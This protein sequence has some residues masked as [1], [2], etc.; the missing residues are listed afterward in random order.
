MPA[1]GLVCGGHCRKAL[2]SVFLYPILSLVWKD[3]SIADIEEILDRRQP[4]DVWFLI[5]SG[6]SGFWIFLT[7]VCVTPALLLLGAGPTSL[8][9]LAIAFVLGVGLTASLLFGVFEKFPTAVARATGSNSFLVIL[10]VVIF[11]ISWMSMAAD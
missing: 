3:S 5:S 7:A 9:R 1:K 10:G 6:L 2:A 4:A 8:L 11:A